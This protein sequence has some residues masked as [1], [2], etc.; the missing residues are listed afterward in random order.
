MVKIIYKMVVGGEKGKE[1]WKIVLFF[2]KQE[3]LSS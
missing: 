2:S 3:T 1:I